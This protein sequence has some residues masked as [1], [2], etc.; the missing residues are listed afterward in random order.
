MTSVTKRDAENCQEHNNPHAIIE[1]RLADD[2]GLQLFWNTCLFKDS[3][4][5]N[6]VGRRN[7]RA[8]QQTIDKLG[9]ESQQR[10][11]KVDRSAD[12]K[13]GRQHT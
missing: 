12:D 3:Q 7:Q 1:Q 8:K 6:R 2:F 11:K 9:S 4:N 5:C 10:K 13:R